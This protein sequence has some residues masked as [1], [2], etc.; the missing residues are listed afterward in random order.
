MAISAY[1]PP[2]SVIQRIPAIP[3]P[4]VGTPDLAAVIIG[5][6]KQVVYREDAGDYDGD[7]VTLAYPGLAN[8]ATVEVASVKA[9]IRDQT[10]LSIVD[11]TDDLTGTSATGVT[12]P[13]G[14]AERLVLAGD[15]E[16]R[17]QATDGTTAAEAS[18]TNGL[19]LSSVSSNFF[20]STPVRIGDRVIFS[21]GTTAI[22][23]GLV[24]HDTLHIVR[25]NGIAFPAGVV[26]ANQTFR[27]VRA[28]NTS[29]STTS[30]VALA[31]TFA[32]KGVRPNDTIYFPIDGS[33]LIITEVQGETVLLFDTIIPAAGLTMITWSSANGAVV[34]SAEKI[35]IGD[36]VTLDDDDSDPITCVVI[37]KNTV[38]Y[39]VDITSWAANVA[40]VANTTHF[41]V[42]DSVVID[43]DD[44]NPI[45]REVTAVTPTT[46]TVDGADPSG[47]YTAAQNATITK[48]DVPSLVLYPDWVF[49]SADANGTPTV[50]VGV[51]NTTGFQAGQT[52]TIDD[53]AN[54]AV[55]GTVNSVDHDAG[56]ITFA[57]NVSNFSVENH[58]RLRIIPNTSFATNPKITQV[59]PTRFRFGFEVRHP[60]TGD[61][62]VSYS[63]TRSATDP[64]IVDDDGNIYIREV[65]INSLSEA[66]GEDSVAS[67]D[68]ILP[69]GASKALANTGGDAV[70]VCALPSD[71]LT[72]HQKAQEAIEI[73]GGV[74]KAHIAPL[75]FNNATQSAWVTF[76]QNQSQDDVKRWNRIYLAKEIDTSRTKGQQAE[77]MRAHGA[78]NNLGVTVLGTDLWYDTVQGEEDTVVAAYFAAA[79]RAGLASALPIGQPQTRRVLAGFT[80]IGHADRYFTENQLNNI[81]SGGIEIYVQP[82]DNAPITIRHA[83]T[84]DRSAFNHANVGMVIARD[85][86]SYTM[87]AAIE[88]LI[89]DANISPAFL[90]AVESVALAVTAEALNLPGNAFLNITE[91]SVIEDPDVEGQIVVSYQTHQG[92]PAL[93]FLTKIYY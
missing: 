33:K 69:Y 52:V 56:T 18:I 40:T 66:Y 64:L 70:Y 63:A 58:A 50:S 3:S 65:D 30:L 26:G 39:S 47:D 37:G 31:E 43:D 14:V 79:A 91:L 7:A 27:I 24:D 72:D 35:S 15:T 32:T 20:G 42:G 51:G 67:P 80:G 46:I 13:A 49:L 71:M 81:A 19:S 90:D 10:D 25:P 75:T 12:L 38:D 86:L 1:K 59:V 4:E 83:L 5:Q 17:A 54:A 84:T 68:S 76:Q 82:T 8:G 9:S 28:R 85:W 48:E 61:V 22:V 44:S 78:Y 93:S 62:L 55:T 77:D 6:L 34:T 45:T 16:I 60:L 74:P 36:T 73:S 87:D 21:G 41:I 92:R 53:D 89:A 29:A 57:A 23:V 11:V 88:P 2:G